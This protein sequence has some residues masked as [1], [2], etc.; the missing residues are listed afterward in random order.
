MQSNRDAFTN[1]EATSIVWCSWSA[2]F[3][4][5]CS[6]ERLNKFITTCAANGDHVWNVVRNRDTSLI[7]LKCSSSSG[8]YVQ[9]E[10]SI[11][12]PVFKPRSK[13]TFGRIQ[14]IQ[15]DLLVFLGEENG[16]IHVFQIDRESGVMLIAKHHPNSPSAIQYISPQSDVFS[17]SAFHLWVLVDNHINLISGVSPATGTNNTNSFINLERMLSFRTPLSNTDKLL[18][19]QV[20]TS[21]F[22]A[23]F[24]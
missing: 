16:S 10:D 9:F 20:C 14:T 1:A 7:A 6:D 24:I 18:R 5:N 17:Q 19:L 23:T 12:L 2:D 4:N 15:N 8:A 11:C 3:C 22:I 13:V 21:L